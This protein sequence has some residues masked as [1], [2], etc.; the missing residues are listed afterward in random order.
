METFLILAKFFG[1]IILLFVAGWLIGHLMKLNKI[2]EKT[3]N[4]LKS[5][6]SKK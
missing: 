2:Y 6:N 1:G 4:E 3:Q 5:K